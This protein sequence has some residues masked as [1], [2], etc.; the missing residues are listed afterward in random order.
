MIY[1]KRTEY[2]ADILKVNHILRYEFSYSF[3]LRSF[4][5]WHLW[6]IGILPQ[7]Y[8]ASQPRRPWL[9]IS[10]L[11]KPQNLHL[12]F[13]LFMIILFLLELMSNGI[14][15]VTNTVEQSHS[16]EANSHSSS[17]GISLFL[18]NPYVHYH[19]HDRPRLIPVLDQMN[20]VQ[21]LHI[22]F[23]KDTF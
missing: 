13:F 7:H 14:A 10:L 20:P 5:L 11:W 17:Q 3:K 18:G 2:V 4:G 6:N 8:T 12:L 23:L 16:W 21:I 22:L 1:W 9:E 15:F 19:V